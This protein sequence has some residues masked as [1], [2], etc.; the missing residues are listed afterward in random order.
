MKR[1]TFA[2]AAI[3]AP[4]AIGLTIAFSPAVSADGSQLAFGG[5][6]YGMGPGA[7]SRGGMMGGQAGTWPGAYMVD[8]DHDGTVT[9]DEVK[10][11]IDSRHAMRGFE[12][13]KVGEIKEADENSITAKI[14]DA[15]GA[16]VRTLTFPRKINAT[17]A[18][19][20][21]QRG[22]GY[23]MRGDRPGGGYA[24]RGGR[25]GY[26]MPGRMG[27]GRKGNYG[28]RGDMSNPDF[29]AGMGYGK[30]SGLQADGEVTIDEI[31][32]LLEQRL[33]MRQNPNLKVGEV[34]DKDEYTIAAQI[35]TK[36]GSL[37]QT[38]EFNKKTGRP[39]WNR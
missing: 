10:K 2:F 12:E 14:L 24:A 37:V 38:M 34:T 8:A 26:N 31:R 22:Q 20:P 19:N 18:T 11:F 9:V 17:A 7:M 27:G 15:K 13:Y 3:I 1:S 23:G 39:V 16:E 36:D 30:T 4:A 28:P 5:P 25:G 21:A 29:R 6:G 32:G 33:A 35:V